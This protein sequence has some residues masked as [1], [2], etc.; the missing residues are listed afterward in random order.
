MILFKISLDP[1]G[2]PSSPGRRQHSAGWPL[3]AAR[4]RGATAGVSVLPDSKRGL[5]VNSPL[6]A[7]VPDAPL[8]LAS[9]AGR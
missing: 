4:L 2:F 5:N 8:S 1:F 6:A 7:S 3:P 9:E